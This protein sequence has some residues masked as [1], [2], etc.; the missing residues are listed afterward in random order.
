MRYRNVNRN[1]CLYQLIKI[2]HIYNITKYKML[3]G[4]ER[5]IR[6]TWVNSIK[7]KPNTMINIM[8]HLHHI[9][10]YMPFAKVVRISMIDFDAF[11]I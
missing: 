2:Q 11:I 1:G 8:H 10:L 5:H 6:I 7:T 4:T 9:H 3:S